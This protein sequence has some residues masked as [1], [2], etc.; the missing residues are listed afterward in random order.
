MEYK[1]EIEEIMDGMECP[2]GFS[3]YEKNFENVC[4][5][6]GVVTEH[7]IECGDNC[8][9]EPFLCKSKIHFGYSSLCSCPLRNFVYR[10][11]QK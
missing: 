3:C 4:E 8:P 7:Y 1:E 6:K 11:L 5:P 10:K 2:Y 9:S